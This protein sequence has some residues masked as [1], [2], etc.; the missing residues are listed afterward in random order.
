MGDHAKFKIICRPHILIVVPRG[1]A[2]KVRNPATAIIRNRAVQTGANTASGGL[3]DGLLSAAYQ[4][5]GR[6][7]TPIRTPAAGTRNRKAAHRYHLPRLRAASGRRAA[8]R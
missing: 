4:A 5:P 3:K 7:R 1:S 8:T 2:S 6:F